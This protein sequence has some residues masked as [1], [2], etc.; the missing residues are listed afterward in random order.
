MPKR[1]ADKRPFLT[2]DSETDPF[3]YGRV[4]APFIWGIFD[5]INFDS[6]DDTEKMIEVIK[7]FDGI[8]YAHSGGRFDFHFILG[9]IN[10][11]EEIKSING[12]LVAARIGRCEIRDSWN[13]IPAP[14]AEFANKYHIEDFSIFEKSERDKKK[15]REEI[16]KRLQSDCEDLWYVI[17][18]NE[19][20]FGRH[21]T[22]AGASMAKWK[23]ISN[24]ESP[25]TDR[26]FFE[27][28]SKF[29]YGG[30]VQKFV[31]GKID[32]PIEVVDIHS[33]YPWA[34]LSEHPYSSTYTTVANPTDI[35]PAS[36]ITVD[37]ISNG[38]LPWRNEKGSIVFPDDGQKR[39]YYVPGH[40]ILCAIDTGS[41]RD[42]SFVEA[43]DFIGLQSFER[44]VSEHYALRLIA[45]ANGDRAGDTLNKMSMN[46][47][48]GKFGANPDNY[49]NFMACEFDDI[50]KF[51]MEYI[52]KN[53]IDI[54]DPE[55]YRFIPQA[56]GMLGPHV[57]MRA[58]LQ[59]H[60]EHYIN[61]ATIASI[62]SQA[63]AKLWRAICSSKGVIYCDTDSIF[64]H[65]AN[66]EIGTE[67]GQWE[68]EG[69]AD[70]A[71][72][73]G[74]KMYYLQG[75]FGLNKKTGKIKTEKKASKGVKLSAGQLKKIALGGTAVYKSDAPTFHLTGKKR[76][77]FQT[78][79]VRA[80]G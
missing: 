33:A 32:G 12:S 67:L 17:E 21:L 37:C 16:I 4:P 74:K 70:I 41:V 61:V 46:G 38:A 10:L 43:I 28:F 65:K 66:V 13:I 36:M 15:N 64:A 56:D 49:G 76:V 24:L 35:K 73:A 42:V 71:W 72:I 6:Y 77:T 31:T 8:V 30:R 52:K 44:Y 45:K 29:Y 1:A 40:E 75:N 60:Q 63:R 58:P 27:K 34:M 19:E 3:K 53:K 51:Q 26:L 2:L 39:T 22:R 80:T 25:K 68:R 20:Q 69:I 7:E 54:F 9:S 79:R 47:L 62:T 55:S 23:S 50:A 78:R 57:L 11:D 18:K 5:G 14:Q 48:S 59:P